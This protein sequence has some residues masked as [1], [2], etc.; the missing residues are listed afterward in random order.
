LLALGTTY[1]A[2]IEGE[3]LLI[4]ALNFDREVI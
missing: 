3:L 1:F 4:L 2:A